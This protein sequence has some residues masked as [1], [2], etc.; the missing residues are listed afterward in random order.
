[1]GANF[2]LG[3]DFISFKKTPRLIGADIKTKEYPG[4][5]TDLQAPFTILLTQARGRSLMHEAIFEG[6][7]NYVKDLNKMGAKVT[8][9]DPQRA[10][11]EGPTPLKG[12]SLKSPDLR[13]GLAFVI[14]ALA[15]KG[16][17][18]I[19]NIYQIDR[20]YENIDKRLLS[21]GANIKRV[22]I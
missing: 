11:V 9:L 20:G 10:M 12:Q 2:E 1:M 16:E 14:A 5:V 21:I 3:K 4:F 17:S 18:E 22:L 7:L 15:A 6:R 8:L 13:A 19:G